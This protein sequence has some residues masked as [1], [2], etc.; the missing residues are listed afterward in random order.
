LIIQTRVS[1]KP[2]FFSHNNPKYE[3][4]TAYFHKSCTKKS[5]RKTNK[6]TNKQTNNHSKEKILFS[7]LDR[8]DSKVSK[9]KKIHYDLSGSLAM[10]SDPI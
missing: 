4:N 2:K 3:Q 10:A 9:Q 8:T 5:Q 7:E 1:G 6:Q